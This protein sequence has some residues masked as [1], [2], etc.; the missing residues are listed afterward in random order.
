M[1]I[2]PLNIS[3]NIQYLIHLSDIHIRTGNKIQSRFIEYKEV[4]DNLIKNLK[5]LNC[6][7][8]KTALII[9]C[10]DIFHN[11]NKV[12]SHGIY[13]FNFFINSLSDLAPL[14]I[15]QGNHDFLQSEKEH[16][17]LLSAFL[18]NPN[19][20]IYY[21]EKTGL[22]TVGNIGFGLIS[23]KDIL[24]SGSTSGQVEIL[25]Q[26]PNPSLFPSNINLKIALFHGTLINSKLD[27]YSISTQGVSFDW[28]NNYNYILLGDI[29]LQS[30]YQQKKIVE[31]CDFIN[32]NNLQ[33]FAYS[34]S[35]IQQNFGENPI[36]H[37]YLL[38]DLNK[39]QI[40]SHKIYNPYRFLKLE[41][42]NL[43]WKLIYKNISLENFLTN[44]KPKYLKIRI[45]G[46]SNF[47]SINKLKNLLDLYKVNYEFSSQLLNSIDNY[48]YKINN[49][50]FKLNIE[51]ITEFNSKD[52]WIQFIKEKNIFENKNFNYNW[53]NWIN[54]PELLKI[55]LDN[56]ILADNF[57]SK[58]NKKNLE[59]D[60]NI[61]KFKKSIDNLI[62]KN[63]IYLNNINFSWLLCFG[64]DCF[65]N[66]NDLK[67]NIGLISANNG[68]GK[69]SFLEIICL[70]LFG[71]SIP[72]RFNK[73]FSA[74][75]ISKQKPKKEISFTQIEFIINNI[76]YILYRSFDTQSNDKNKLLIK[77]VN[78]FK[79]NNDKQELIYSGNNAVNNWI[80]QNIGNIN[81][82]LLSC[83][84][85]QNQDQDFFNIK[86]D[87]QI[88]LL[89]NCLNFDSV[90]SLTNLFKIVSNT[91]KYVIDH[92]ETLFNNAFKNNKSDVSIET[93]L[94]FKNNIKNLENKICLYEE[95]LD[96]I[97]ESWFNLEIN[98]LELDDNDINDK[99]DTYDKQLTE[100]YNL[101]KNF[102]KEYL[103]DL[104]EKKGSIKNQINYD[105]IKD[106]ELNKLS[107]N[108]ILETLK[109][110]ELSQPSKPNKTKEII[111]NDEEI[112]KKWKEKN[113]ILFKKKILEKDLYLYK[114]NISEI[115]T[116]IKNYY[117]DLQLLEKPCTKPN[118][119]NYDYNNWLKNYNKKIE[120]Y[121]KKYLDINELIKICDKNP[122]VK[123]SISKDDLERSKFDLTNE[124]DN[125]LITEISNINIT[126]DSIISIKKKF[127]IEYDEILNKIKMNNDHIENYETFEKNIIN[128][129]TALNR[130]EK[131]D[132][133]LETC[134]D[135]IDYINKI[136]VNYFTI[137]KYIEVYNMYQS[138]ELSIEEM[139]Y[140][141]KCKACN[142]NPIRIQYRNICQELDEIRLLLKE[143]NCKYENFD[144]LKN[145]FKEDQNDL[146]KE[147][148]YK[149]II[150]KW[151]KY[152]I[153][154]KEFNEFSS[155]LDD[156]KKKI[157]NYKELKK[158]LLK[159]KKNL[160]FKIEKIN[161][162][163]NNYSRWKN[164]EELINSQINIWNNYEKHIEDHNILENWLK[165]NN[166]YNEWKLLNKNIEL[167]NNY[168]NK[169]NQIQIEIDQ[170][171]KHLEIEN[172]SYNEILLFLKEHNDWNKVN[173]ENNLFI[174]QWEIWDA[175]N[176]EYYR[177]LNF[178]LY[179]D[180]QLIDEDVKNIKN[181]YD[182]EKKKKYWESIKY[183]KK[184]YNLKKKINILLKEAKIELTNLKHQLFINQN[185][186]DSYIKEKNRN[187]IISKLIEEYSNKLIMLNLLSNAFSEYRIWLYKFK[188]IPKIL[189]YTNNLVRSVCSYNTIELQAEMNNSLINWFL[190]DGI[191]IVSIDKASG[192]Q[193][194]IIGIAIRISLSYL[195]ASTVLCNQLFIDEG[196]TS[197]DINHLQKIPEFIHSLLNLYDSVLL[198][199]H[200]HNIQDCV[201]ISIPISR[202]NS[203]SKIQFG[204]KSMREIKK[205]R[206]K[207]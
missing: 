120:T 52:T 138:I 194:F 155:K 158:K 61:N 27:N 40:H 119:N 108:I 98:D 176:I 28:F 175:W 1:E 67:S 87:E 18:H 47:Y 154:I 81:K 180:L 64:K 181:I 121:S 132:I 153:F 90:N 82:F 11:K 148:Y 91:Y 50:N 170:L 89:D 182:L 13:L 186:Y 159:K 56:N 16:V 189:F 6:I 192:F 95:Q 15:I 39:F 201:D 41:F 145:K 163:E 2:L 125:S 136:H 74:S 107:Y 147:I 203:L 21:L 114:N 24:M 5:E 206:T 75:I 135:K 92:L 7:K 22:Y 152:N 79:I 83:M 196:F 151:S 173:Q 122:I 110:I 17:D 34:G 162:I 178:K 113:L 25:P 14:I 96:T 165:L 149:D 102:S 140:N 65:F 8:E 171:E 19:K 190:K 109:K 141:P 150:N 204:Q 143:S 172:N 187:D 99:L 76:I 100:L 185:N 9:L 29:H 188:V 62:I 130:Y 191:N 84:I 57:L 71:Q 68:Y 156:I 179:N 161:Y 207:K 97:K 197:C 20:N 139:P 101:Y 202:E 124:I 93:I 31:S 111:K 167:Y 205:Q 38:W 116:K 164:S 30:I 115:N 4:F 131:P 59:I 36:D 144:L 63:N 123:P 46:N 53:E 44:E 198:V 106:T 126:L 3:N 129:I 104:L 45:I 48:N 177:F 157:K 195:G 118:K 200:L 117:K 78:L 169:R 133:L 10:G 72:S 160:E 137:K 60:I 86:Q 73:T 42:K 12:E 37:G 80:K 54:N 168:Y 33:T 174:K 70:S 85:T 166:E 43:E 105:L 112:Y 51:D 142:K 184:N 55:T 103:E 183:S 94:N 26:F 134:L 32:I 193:R 127:I 128:K 69:S 66:F 199:S 146:E 23:I 88:E 77:N 35:L 49:E 58:I